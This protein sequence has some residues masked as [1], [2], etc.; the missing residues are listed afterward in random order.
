MSATGATEGGDAMDGPGIDQAGDGPVGPSVADLL[1][2]LDVA[3]L[4]AASPELQPL[5]EIIEASVLRVLDCDRAGVFVL[6]ERANELVGRAVTG[7]KNLRFPADRGVAGAALREGVAIR[8]ADAHLDPR[9]NPEVDR[10]TGYRTRSLLSIPIRGW[11]DRPVGVLMALN[12]HGGIFDARDEAVAA[13]LGV[14]VGVAIQRQLLLDQAEERRQL[15]RD[16]D[17]ARRIQQGL[18]P[19]KPPRVEGYDLAGWN[20]PADQ[21][22]GDFF[23][24]Q[25]L[26][27]GTLALTVADVA[28]HGI[29]PALLVAECRALVRATLAQ[30]RDPARLVEVVDRLISEDLPED[31]F[32]TLF[33]ALLE[34]GTGRL[35]FVSAGHGPVLLHRRS[36]GK[37]EELPPHG[38]PLGV[39]PELTR[40]EAGETVLEPGDVLGIFTDGMGEWADVANRQFGN[41]RLGEAL[42][43]HRDLPGPGL[44]AAIHAD[45]LAFTGGTPQPDDLTAVILKRI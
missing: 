40:D 41:T 11:D 16:L 2:V 14:Q 34:P 32:I 13:A 8:L 7:E 38:C 23:D 29:G 6:D 4:L 33:F 27:D 24:L 15:G 35:R 20:L 19:R 22:G 36:S 21:T 45:L 39:A 1:E 25:R 42:G 31:R 12:K 10:R 37:V 18:M 28:G 9:F 26:D 43:R 44:I 30:A 17:V 3:R 5:L